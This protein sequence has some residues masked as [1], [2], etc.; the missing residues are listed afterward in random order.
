MMINM[1]SFHFILFGGFI[2]SANVGRFNRDKSCSQFESRFELNQ[3]N[4]NFVKNSGAKPEN[5]TFSFKVTPFEIIIRYS[6]SIKQ[7]YN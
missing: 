3:V 6:D 5:V 1:T 2:G 4:C 7:K